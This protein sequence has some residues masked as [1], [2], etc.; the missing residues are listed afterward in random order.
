MTWMIDFNLKEKKSDRVKHGE[1]TTRYKEHA[2]VEAK[3][4]PVYP[5]NRE[6]L[7]LVTT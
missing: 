2:I 4:L 3:M 6:F 1:L 5:K 7:S